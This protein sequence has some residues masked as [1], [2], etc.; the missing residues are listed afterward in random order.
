VA[1]IAAIASR[2][3]R[4]R[5]RLVGLVFV[6]GV[7]LRLPMLGAPH[8]EGDEVIYMSLVSQLDHGYGY[9]LQGTPLVELGL[10][11]RYQYDRPLFYHPPG[12]IVLFWMAYKMFGESG[13]ALTQMSCFAVFFWSMLLFAHCLRITRSDSGLFVVAVLSSF[14]PLLAHVTTK[15]WLDAPLA[16]C[17]TLG[18]ALFLYS[19]VKKFAGAIPS[20][21]RAPDAFSAKKPSQQRKSKGS[22]HA[23]KRPLTGD[24][25]P[26]KRSPLR[27]GAWAVAAGIVVGYASLIKLTALLVVPGVLLVCMA[28]IRPLPRKPVVVHA[29]YFVIPAVIVQMPWELW[30]WLVVGSPFPQWAGKPSET[31]VRS[32][33]YVAFLTVA[34]SPWIYLTLTPL[35]LTTIVPSGFLHL[36]QYARERADRSLTRAGSAFDVHRIATACLVWIL[37]IIAFHVMLGYAGYSKL[38]RYVILIAPATTLLPALLL[39][40]DGDGKEKSGRRSFMGR[41]EAFATLC[42]VVGIVLEIGT[43]IYVA[44]QVQRALIVPFTGL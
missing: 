39:A 7:L 11:D 13:F 23:G 31:L 33:G 38:L 8:R 43:G 25:S 27:P 22:N 2:V 44:F 20:E 37:L 17:A 3:L 18:G 36:I 10:L 19:F 9:T 14:N 40:S 5:W 28:L 42:L 4:L 16:A 15:Y 32:N 21:L 41:I 30:Q 26:R 35:V 1:G 29:L 12:G 6:A 34:R 24:A